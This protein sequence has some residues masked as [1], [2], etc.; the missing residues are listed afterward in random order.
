MYKFFDILISV[1]FVLALGA[2]SGASAKGAQ[3]LY[4]SLNLPGFTSPPWLFNVI[5]TALYIILGLILYRLF[6]LDYNKNDKQ[7]YEANNWFIVQLAI[8][9]LWAPIFFMFFKFW[10]A[11]FWLLLLAVIAAITFNKIRKFDK[12]SFYLSIPYLIWIVYALVLNFVI[13]AIN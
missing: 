9:L 8:S 2:I 1:L 11:A 5:W 4:E 10:F 7:R 12:I 3:G 13:A 6:F